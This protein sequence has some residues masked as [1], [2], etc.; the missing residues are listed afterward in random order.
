MKNFIN[1]ADGI[2]SNN[3]VFLYYKNLFLEMQYDYLSK[4]EKEYIIDKYRNASERVL[5][6]EKTIN[7]FKYAFSDNFTLMSEYLLHNTKK[8]GYIVDLGCGIGTQSI[9][10]ALFGIKVLA[11]DLDSKALKIFIKRISFYEKIFNQKLEIEIIEKNALEIDFSKYNIGGV[12]SMFAFN[13]MQPSKLLLK[14]LSKGFNKNCKIAIIDGNNENW[15]PKVFPSQRRKNTLS[16]VLMKK[17]LKQYGFKTE[18]LYGAF[19]L[20][21]IFWRYGFIIKPVNF[22]DEI[23]SKNDW[24]FPRAY[25]I[26]AS[27]TDNEK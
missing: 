22:I 20:L 11:I 8:S 2:I 17:E 25:I 14:N 18:K 13:I 27:N 16:P 24:L 12:F 4:K 7:Y 1:P 15:I 21:N 26:L 3:L 5:L 10:F 9:F 19:S 23:L 6:N